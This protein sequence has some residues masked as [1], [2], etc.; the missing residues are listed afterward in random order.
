MADSESIHDKLARVR[1]PHVHITYKVFTPSG[2]VERELPFVVGVMGDFSGNPT[3][4]LKPLRDREF[5]MIDRDNFDDIMKRMHPGLNLK[6]QNTLAGD[7]SELGVQLKFSS[8]ADF[9]PGKVA[10]QVPAM[11]RLLDLRE[12]L[13]AL[14]NQADR[15]PELE[16]LLE[17]IIQ[18]SDQIKTAIKEGKDGAK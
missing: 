16:T 7:G 6:V 17:Q 4:P 12:Q 8:M 5:A 2:E 18:N 9:E 10:Q 1:K 3:E 15:S 14:L 11:K 13:K